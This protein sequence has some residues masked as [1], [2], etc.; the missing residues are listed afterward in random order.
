LSPKKILVLGASGGVGREL[1]RQALERGL[2]VTAL[3]RRRDG[4]DPR[5]T[6]VLDDVLRPGCFDLVLAGHDA[7]LSALGLKRRSP[8]NP[9]ST[10]VS[11]P[12]FVSRTARALV[13]AMWRARVPRLVAVSAAG[14]ADSAPRM[15]LVMKFLVARSRI[16]IAYRDLAAM[17]AIYAASGL[18][19]CCPRP[20]RLTDGARTQRVRV[21]E[22]FPLAAAISRADVAWWMLEQVAAKR[23]GERRPMISAA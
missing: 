10:L 19:W 3:A 12:D 22:A 16:G 20:T 21:I 8:A 2:A 13:D 14:V 1:V 7:V 4:I 18:D 11:P 5:A 17:E 6:L 23:L 9:W 15:N